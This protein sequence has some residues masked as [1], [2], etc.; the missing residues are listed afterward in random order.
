MSPLL[1]AH[2]VRATGKVPSWVTRIHIFLDNAGSTNKNQ[3]L[4]SS[5][6]ELVQNRVVH[7]LRVSFMTPGHTKFAPDILFSHIARSYY[8]SDVF[9]ETDL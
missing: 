8:K 5:C 2:Y 9:N 7:Y 3:Y 1:L 6:M 4:M